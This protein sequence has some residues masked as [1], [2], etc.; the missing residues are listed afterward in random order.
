MDSELN[1]VIVCELRLVMVIRSHC[2][3]ALDQIVNLD[4]VNNDSNLVPSRI[5]NKNNDDKEERIT[6]S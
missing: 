5:A 4:D 1:V 6:E 3:D 2:K